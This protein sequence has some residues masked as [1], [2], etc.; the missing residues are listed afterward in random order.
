MSEAVQASISSV[1][2]LASSLDREF[3]TLAQGM[4]AA[5]SDTA[6]SVLLTVYRAL[7]RLAEAARPLAA[8]CPACRASGGAGEYEQVNKLSGVWT[9]PE[10]P[11]CRELSHLITAVETAARKVSLPKTH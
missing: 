3:I 10:C 1:Q 8:A 9:R 6:R 11:N 4:E 2:E 5:D 7:F